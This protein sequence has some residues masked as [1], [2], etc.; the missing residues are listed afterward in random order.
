MPLF[1]HPSGKQFHIAEIPRNSALP[2]FTQFGL[3]VPGVRSQPGR[4][5]VAGNSAFAKPGEFNIRHIPEVMRRRLNWPVAAQVMEKWF[6]LPAR[7]M[8]ENEKNGSFPPSSIP[9]AYVNMDLISWA[10]LDRFE[11]VGEA[12]QQLLATIRGN[13]AQEALATKLSQFLQR[14]PSIAQQELHSVRLEGNDPPLLHSRWQF[15]FA[16]VGYKPATGM[17][18]LYGALGQ[19]A[20]YGAVTR[21]AITKLAAQRYRLDVSEIGLYAR[22]TFDFLGGQYL[23]HWGFEGMGILPAALV[24]STGESNREWPFWAYSPSHGWLK[25]INNSDFRLYQ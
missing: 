21:G 25:P 6:E 11:R 2:Q 22:D 14:Q 19:F 20:I 8:L 5:P 10:W 1:R 18:D 9:N 13:K 3:A 7:E 17:D 4:T 24:V 16:G 15:Q 12:E 23:G